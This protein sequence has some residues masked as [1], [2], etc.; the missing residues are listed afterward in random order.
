LKLGAG[1]RI[2]TCMNYSPLVWK[3]SAL[4]LELHLRI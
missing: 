1:D 3:T 2:R 4:P